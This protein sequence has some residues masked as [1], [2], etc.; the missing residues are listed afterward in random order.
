MI[1]GCA[2]NA[3]RESAFENTPSDMMQ[4]TDSVN[5]QASPST[6]EITSLP[7]AT[8]SHPPPAEETQR[9]TPVEETSTLFPS[10]TPTPT[11]EMTAAQTM[12]YCPAGEV[13]VP[14]LLY[15][16]ISPDPPYSK[17][18]VSQVN[19]SQQMNTLVESGYTTI[20]LTLLTETMRSGGYIPSR[21]VII[22]FDDGNEDIYLY[23]FPIMQKLGLSGVF[24]IIPPRIGA[25]GIAK[26]DQIKEMLAAGWEIG[27]HSMTHGDLTQDNINPNY[28]IWQS[29][30]QLEDMFGISVNT[31][32]Y[33]YGSFN[34]FIADK[35]YKY[36][37]QTAMGLGKSWKH[38][39]ASLLYL[40][41]IA[42]LGQYDLIDFISSL[43]WPTTINPTPP[44]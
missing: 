16:H 9:I 43:P 5:R 38:T 20:P 1:S 23:A 14:I 25:N 8:D 11:Q 30:L 40:S 4:I 31:F 28:E 18:F 34:P 12:V 17:Y 21:P 13:T 37:Y 10:R 22:T 15:H 36:G 41:R 27:S 19:F 44:E 6:V 26:K 32:A 2:T 35:V 29:K 24:Y 39:P 3:D 7:S 42:I 33:P